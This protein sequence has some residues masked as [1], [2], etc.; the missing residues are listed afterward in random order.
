MFFFW[1]AFHRLIFVCLCVCVSQRIIII[2]IFISRVKADVV[3]S[4]NRRHFMRVPF[5]LLD[6][7]WLRAQICIFRAIFYPPSLANQMLAFPYLCVLF[8]S[9]FFHS[10]VVGIVV[11]KWKSS[12]FLG[13][14]C[15]NDLPLLGFSIRYRRPGKSKHPAHTHTHT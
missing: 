2:F 4:V 14:N 1:F 3:L 7:R 13:E 15:Q 10:V 9:I 11:E 12:G 6:V 5:A 8:S